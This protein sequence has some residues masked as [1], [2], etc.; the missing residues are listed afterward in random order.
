[1]PS[2]ALAA[3][4]LIPHAPSHSPPPQPS[5]GTGSSTQAQKDRTGHG[6]TSAPSPLEGTAL[7]KANLSHFR[8]VFP[9]N[10]AH[11]GQDHSLESSSCPPADL[12]SPLL[13]GTQVVQRGP[14]GQDD[15]AELRG[16]QRQQ[17][18]R[19]GATTRAQHDQSWHPILHPWPSLKTASSSPFSHQPPLSRRRI[20]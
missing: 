16:W 14:A 9:A 20:P 15:S 1:M 6:D 4:W 7:K 13:L 5:L 10:S 3:G 12:P 18:A 11:T 17:A 8:S 2:P 19:A